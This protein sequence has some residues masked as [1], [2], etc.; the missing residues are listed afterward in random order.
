VTFGRWK[1]ERVRLN[2]EMRKSLVNLWAYAYATGA[3]R[4]L[5]LV[6]ERLREYAAAQATGEDMDV[7][8]KLMVDALLLEQE[9]LQFGESMV[10]KFEAHSGGEEPRSETGG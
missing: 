1:K 6:N 3:K 2:E 5:C 9:A 8:A 4:M 7:K 10:A